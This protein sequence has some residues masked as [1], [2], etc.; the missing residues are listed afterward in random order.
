MMSPRRIGGAK[1]PGPA[2]SSISI[3]CSPSRRNCWTASSRLTASIVPSC[4]LPRA[5]RTRYSKDVSDIL[6][7]AAHD[8]GGVADV[9]RD[10]EDFLDRRDPFADLAK[11]VLPQSD[12]AF[13]RG[14]V[15]HGRDRRIADD[16]VA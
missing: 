13:A 2:S 11:A 12:H 1:R 16:D 8:F 9:A 10:V 5:S 15:L 4:S 14:R 3:T 6:L 7:G